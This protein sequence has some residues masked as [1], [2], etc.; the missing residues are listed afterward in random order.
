[1]SQILG[2]NR[3]GSGRN[4]GLSVEPYCITYNLK[5]SELIQNTA[6]MKEP[7]CESL[8][9]S[10]CFAPWVLSLSSPGF[11]ASKKYLCPGHVM[12]ESGLISSFLLNCHD[13][14]SFP[15]QLW[16]SGCHWK[17]LLWYYPQ[18]AKEN[19]WFGACYWWDFCVP[20]LTAVLA[21]IRAQGT[22][23][24]ENEQVR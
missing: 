8:H 14:F 23:L 17:W 7:S 10:S 1:M 21:G 16:T 15:R 9:G 3:A 5:S 11:F 20:R 22:W 6:K 24:W 2:L 4:H 13:D 18:I 19:R 12:V